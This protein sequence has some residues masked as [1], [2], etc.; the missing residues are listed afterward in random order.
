MTRISTRNTLSE[1]MPQFWSVFCLR[2]C[3]TILRLYRGKLTMKKWTTTTKITVRQVWNCPSFPRF[4]DSL[5][6]WVFWVGQ[7]RVLIL[8][9]VSQY[10]DVDVNKEYIIRGNAGILK[11]QT[12]SFIGD[13]LTVVSWQTDSNET[14]YASD[15][16]YGRKPR[17]ILTSRKNVPHSVFVW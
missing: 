6:L 17:K 14:F 5:L 11:C 4:H 8:P 12:P 3:P 16:N 9:V 13:F 10:Y 2:T 15:T 1:E 7:L